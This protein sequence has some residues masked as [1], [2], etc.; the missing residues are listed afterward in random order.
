M[1]TDIIKV[2][3]RSLFQNDK[4]PNDGKIKLFSKDGTLF[5]VL[6]RPNTGKE[7]LFLKFTRWL[8]NEKN[9]ILFVTLDSTKESLMKRFELNYQLSLEHQNILIEEQVVSLE[10]I[11]QI[12]QN[13][14]NIKILMIDNIKLLKDYET[15]SDQIMKGLSIIKEQGVSTIVAYPLEKEETFERKY[16]EL[17]TNVLQIEN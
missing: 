14:P 12:I 6:Y 13:D 1:A 10:N 8:L 2:T 15:T 9:K 3:S 7:L 17:A 5:Y 16:I 11:Q 4:F